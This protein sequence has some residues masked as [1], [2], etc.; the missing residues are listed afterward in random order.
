MEAGRFRIEGHLPPC[1]PSAFHPAC[2]AIPAGFPCALG[3]RVAEGGGVGLRVHQGQRRHL[4]EV[5]TDA[6][7]RPKIGLARFIFDRDREWSSLARPTP[8]L[9]RV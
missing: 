8:P 9:C 2:G 1:W 4:A 3:G 6:L 5:L 7:D